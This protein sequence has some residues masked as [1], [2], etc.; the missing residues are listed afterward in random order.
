MVGGSRFGFVIFF[1]FWGRVGLFDF[2][3]FGFIFVCRIYGN[4]VFLVWGFVDNFEFIGKNLYL[5]FCY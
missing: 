4:F 2:N 1:R 3:C 5:I